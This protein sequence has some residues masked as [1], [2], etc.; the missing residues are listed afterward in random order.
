LRDANLKA[1]QE[2]DALSGKLSYKNR[3]EQST[4][5]T[6]WKCKEQYRNIQERIRGKREAIKRINP[7]KAKL[8]FRI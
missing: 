2:I 5:S 4:K 1:I 3:T 7:G 6:I 8:R